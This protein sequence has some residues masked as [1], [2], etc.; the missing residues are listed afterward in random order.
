[1]IVVPLAA[2]LAISFLYRADLGARALAVYALLWVAA[3]ALCLVLSLSPGVFTALQCALAV[4]L[5][6]HVRAN[7]R[8]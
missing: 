7:P 2:L 3:L 5:L 8:L 1:M 6:I 4:A